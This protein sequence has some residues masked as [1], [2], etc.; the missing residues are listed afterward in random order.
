MTNKFISIVLAFLISVTVVLG[1]ALAFLY[2]YLN[3]DHLDG[4]MEAIANFL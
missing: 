4:I 3:T 1:G 2:L